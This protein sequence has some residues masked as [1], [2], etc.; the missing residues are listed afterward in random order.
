MRMNRTALIHKEKEC[1]K[2]KKLKKIFSK[3]L[4]LE[5]YKIVKNFTI[6]KISKTLKDKIPKYK[7]LREEFIAKH[8]LCQAN[9]CGCT[10]ASTEIHH[11]KGRIGK[12]LLYVKY[13][14]AV[15]S[16]CHTYITENSKWA[17][18]NNFSI[19]RNTNDHTN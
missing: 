13:W 14:L 1:R 2:C 6:N 9:I 18:E 8:P 19:K 15:C 3:G 17:I 7:D 4:C 10:K 11:K 5:C 16:H 12:L